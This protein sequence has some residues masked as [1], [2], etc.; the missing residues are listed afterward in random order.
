MKLLFVF[1]LC[2]VAH[3]VKPQLNGF[4]Y[5]TP[6]AKGAK[7]VVAKAPKLATF[8]QV[9]RMKKTDKSSCYNFKISTAGKSI[10]FEESLVNQ[11]VTLKQTY[12]ANAT[13]D[14]KWNVTLNSEC[15][16]LR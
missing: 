2:F 9:M 6:P 8:Y 15:S 10:K 4:T 14:G 3:E 7:K 13:D 1:V 12:M 11:N 16:R 5:C